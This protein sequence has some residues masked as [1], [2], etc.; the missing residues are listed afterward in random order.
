MLLIPILSKTILVRLKIQ[1]WWFMPVE[2]GRFVIQAYPQLYSGCE[3]WLDCLKLSQKNPSF[4]NFLFHRIVYQFLS[5][6]GL[7]EMHLVFGYFPI[8]GYRV[9]LIV[10]SNYLL[11]NQ[12]FVLSLLLSIF[13]FQLPRFLL[14][15]TGSST[16]R[17]MYVQ[18]H[19]N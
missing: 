8:F 11:Y 3:T 2:G 4:L 19:Y 10:L 16:V 14:S 1:M 12:M 15:T 5:C 9:K 13:S 17:H 7:E 18:D 6:V